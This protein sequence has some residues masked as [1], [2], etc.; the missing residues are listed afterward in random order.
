M[1]IDFRQLFPK[2]GIS[3]IGVCH[4]GGNIGEEFPVYMELGIKKQIW[5]EANPKMYEQLVQNISSNKEAIAYCICAG[6]EN[7]NVVLH[8]S[9][10]SGQSSSVLELGTHKEVHPEVHYI[11]D[12]EVPMVRME[13]FLTPQQFHSV[14]FLNIDVQGFELN[15]LKG[16]GNYLHNFNAIYLEVN[17]A[18]LYVGCPLVEDLDA[19]LLI[20]GFT[21]VETM[22]CGNTNWGDALWIKV[23]M[24][25]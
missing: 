10:N 19:Y 12:I 20:Y 25:K 3:P 6:D 5:V 13:E 23:G 11:G 4:I 7:K 18:E 22:W 16:I 2:Y 14:D 15:V 1:L 21:R 9:N 24:I 17:K 8:E